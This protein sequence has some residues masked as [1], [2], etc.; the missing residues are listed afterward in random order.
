MT[1]YKRKGEEWKETFEHMTKEFKKQ[2]EKFNK[3]MRGAIKL[4]PGREWEVTCEEEAY[5]PDIRLDCGDGSS[6]KAYTDE[7]GRMVFKPQKREE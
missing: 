3:E 1:K 4:D 6:V 7:D 5:D 2:I